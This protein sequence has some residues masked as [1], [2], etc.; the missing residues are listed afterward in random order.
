MLFDEYDGLLDQSKIKSEVGL[1]Y[2]SVYFVMVHAIKFIVILKLK[3]TNAVNIK[4]ED[5]I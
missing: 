2:N 5:F 1:L 4:I 3:I